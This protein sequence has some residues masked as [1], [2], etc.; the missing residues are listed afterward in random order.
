MKK[1]LFILQLIVIVSCNNVEQKNKTTSLDLNIDNN[2]SFDKNKG[3]II[4]N[5]YV[6]T[7]I[8]WS[9]IIPQN[10]KV[11]YPE[12]INEKND[13]IPDL[14]KEELSSNYLVCFEMDDNNFFFS[15]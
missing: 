1:S 9:I 5:E 14:I 3:E 4:D 10:N 8:G 6:N 7:D 12:A 2:K 15:L 11:Y 13:E